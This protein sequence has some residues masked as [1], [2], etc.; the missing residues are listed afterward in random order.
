MKY[1]ELSAIQRADLAA[2]DRYLRG[3]FSS[4]AAIARQADPDQWAAFAAAN[5]DPLLAQLADEA[6]I[7][8]ATGLGGAKEL[9]AAEFR[10][11]QAIG[12]ALL[13]SLADERA[14]LVK[15]VGVNV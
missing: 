7:P 8:N 4:L 3:V 1:E 15:A 6:A 9:T 13:A 11:L 12:R 14:L 2:Y 10:R 5:V